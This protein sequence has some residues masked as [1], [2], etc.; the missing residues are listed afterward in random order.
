MAKP[1]R[2]LFQ[3]GTKREIKETSAKG[4]KGITWSRA[5]ESMREIRQPMDGEV[6]MLVTRIR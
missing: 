6:G 3:V 4:A 1:L 2:Y 5:D